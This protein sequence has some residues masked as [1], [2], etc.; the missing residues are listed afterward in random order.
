[1]ELIIQTILFHIIKHADFIDIGHKIRPYIIMDR[2]HNF[3]TQSLCHTK[4]IHRGHL[5]SHTYRVLP[6][7][8]KRYIHI[9]ILAMLCKINRIMGISAVV[10]ISS[11][12]PEQI[13]YCLIIHICRADPGQFLP[14]LTGIIG[15]HQAGS[16]KGIQSNDLN[17]LNPDCVSRFY[18]DAPLCRHSPLLPEFHRFLRADKRYRN[19]LSLFIGCSHTAPDHMGGIFCAHMILVVMS[20]QNSIYLF[21]GK[22][23]NHK[24]HCS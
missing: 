4:D 23:I 8:T 19:R 11:R 21:D 24:W 15:R 13:I 10:D 6:I 20:R 5:I 22:G 9:I 1:M 14:V 7:G 16:V 3:S 2:N 17:I 12:R 18:C